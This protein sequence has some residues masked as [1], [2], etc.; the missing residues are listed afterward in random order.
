MLRRDEGGQGFVMN[1]VVGS[2]GV[3]DTDGPLSQAD[4][5]G[6]RAGRGDGVATAW[7]GGLVVKIKT[8]VKHEIHG[9]SKVCHLSVQ[10][11]WWCPG[12][13]GAT[14]GELVRPNIGT[15]CDSPST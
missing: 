10:R 6:Q 5:R 14:G 9:S 8:I 13:V 11:Q 2:E 15:G 1:G 7:T 4:D 3:V 12:P